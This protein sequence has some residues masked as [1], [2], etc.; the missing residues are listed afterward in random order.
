[1][2][3]QLKTVDTKPDQEVVEFLEKQ[4]LR[5]KSG[6]IRGVIIITTD[7][8]NCTSNGWI[9]CE[10]NVMQLVGELEAA[11]FDFIQLNVDLRANN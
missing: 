11:K 7:T 3:T 6:E 8:E 5:A 1:M 9:G 4:V 2:I 10:G